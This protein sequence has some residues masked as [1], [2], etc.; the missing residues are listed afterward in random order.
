MRGSEVPATQDTLSGLGQKK[1]SACAVPVCAW[2]AV[3]VDRCR[4][5]LQV[6]AVSACAGF[7]IAGAAA[8]DRGTGGLG[9]TDRSKERAG[10]SCAPGLGKRKGS[11]PARAVGTE[12]VH[13]RTT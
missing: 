1:C 13:V 8:P 9:L 5:G 7:W 2:C 12:E 6:H 10:T 3:S 4:P 11:T